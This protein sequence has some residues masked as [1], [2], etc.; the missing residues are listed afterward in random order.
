MTIRAI[1]HICWGYIAH[2]PM[3]KAA[4]EIS[5]NNLA[6]QLHFKSV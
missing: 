5:R 4:A 2:L 6:S 1:A 3:L